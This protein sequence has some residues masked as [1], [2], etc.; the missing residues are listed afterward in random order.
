AL[1]VLT[2]PD[3]Y[4]VC[5]PARSRSCAGSSHACAA[6][7]LC[8]VPYVVTL[9]RPA[10]KAGHR[11]GYDADLLSQFYPGACP[12]FKSALTRGTEQG[13]IPGSAE[14]RDGRAVGVS[15]ELNRAAIEV[16]RQGCARGRQP[17]TA[18]PV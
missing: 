17:S 2:V 18:S 16:H 7:A 10:P 11:S 4:S 1:Q 9:L 6:D 8:C 15:E 12:I 13:P 14:R 3:G 5:G